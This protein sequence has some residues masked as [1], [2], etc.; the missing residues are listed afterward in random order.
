MKRIA[1]ELFLLSL[2][3]LFF[4]LLVIRWYSADIRAFTVF[5]TFP[6]ITCFVGMGVGFALR[7]DKVFRYGLMS[8]VLFL[9]I[10]KHVQWLGSGTLTFP[11]MSVWAFNNYEFVPQAGRLVSFMVVLLYCLAGPFTAMLC[12]G[13]RLGVLFDR[14]DALKAYSVNITGSI[15]GSIAFTV[16]CYAQ[17]PPPILFLLPVLLVAYYTPELGIAQLRSVGAVA[18]I[19]ALASWTIPPPTRENLSADLLKNIEKTTVWSPYQRIDLTLFRGQ[20]DP[21]KQQPP[22]GLELGV[23][24]FFYQ[25]YFDDNQDLSKVSPDLGKLIT[26]RRVH[27]ELPY[28]YQ[29]PQDVLI[30]GAGTGQDVA[31]A[32]KHGA[33]HI[34]AVDID[35]VILET[36]RKYNPAYTSD[37]V[38]LICDDARHY[39][40]TTKKKYDCVV[41]SLL[42]SQAVVG[43]GSSVRLDSYVYSKD[44]LEKALTLLKDDGVLVLSF[45]MTAPWTYGHLTRTIEAVTGQPALSFYMS[46]PEKT[47]NVWGGLT[48]FVVRKGDAFKNP[49][50]PPDHT[51]LNVDGVKQQGRVLSDD[52]PYLYVNPD[53]VDVPYLL[54]LLECLLVAALAGRKLLF[55]KY[56]ARNWQMFF[57]GA[58]FM[59]LELQSISRLSL[60]YGSTWI[61]SSIVINGVLVMI[62]LAN[63][64]VIK[65]QGWLSNKLPV[66]YALQMV[67]IVT[68]Y[69]FPARQMMTSE[70]GYALTTAVVLSPMFMAAMIFSTSFGKVRSPSRSLGFNLFGAVV[71]GLME[72]LSNYLGINNMLLLAAGLYGASAFFSSAADKGPDDSTPAG[73]TATLDGASSGQPA[74]EPPDT[75]PP[76]TPPPVPTS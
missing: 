71:G 60:L 13:S 26:D 45:G 31:A 47:S 22:L 36:G 16:L 10:F 29:K 42:D 62:L 1:V 65:K 75:E 63:W 8:M 67:S 35:P 6:L 57:L 2:A 46:T 17:L 41:F 72:F 43:Q 54:V 74:D 73:N 48:Y 64:L 59:L 27:Y 37:K 14:M 28:H 24:H 7:S 38:S 61:T 70:A 5:K 33:Q 40:E 68:S 49:E 58:G 69:F 12:I 44:S 76:V 19:F 55:G 4:E 32:L 51:R 9:A 25:F 39:L 56:E 34:D 50:L 11:T 15:V 30:L 66:L 18:A 3:S 53:V 20:D 52:W 23:N 21:S